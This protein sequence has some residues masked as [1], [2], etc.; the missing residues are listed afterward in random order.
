MSTAADLAPA[1]PLGGDS[2][3]LA[4][5]LWH[6]ALRE[7]P[8][9][10]LADRAGRLL[11]ASRGFAELLGD[12]KRRLPPLL[13]D[14]LK[15]LA[16]HPYEMS[17]LVELAG[18]RFRAASF[19]VFAEDGELLGAAGILEPAATAGTA[20]ATPLPAGR[21]AALTV[22]VDE[23]E[24]RM[25]ELESAFTRAAEESG[26]KTKLLATVSHELR[27]PLTAIAGFAEL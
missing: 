25:A 24:R 17:E 1:P 10:Y 20:P 13:R 11:F 5:R 12:D 18:R 27:T 16:D 23:A 22:A 8:C 3:S 19:P 21:I 15:R 26:R 4:F 7:A 9:P 6:A 2:A 14:G